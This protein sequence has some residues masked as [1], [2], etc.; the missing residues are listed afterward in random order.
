MRP[1]LDRRTLIPIALVALLAVARSASAW[2]DLGH[3]IIAVVAQANLTPHAAREVDRLLAQDRNG[4]R[5]RDGG[6]TADSFARQAAWADYYREAQRA[7][8]KP[9]EL[10]RSYSWHFVNIDV[11]GGS[12]D[13][14]CSDFPKLAPGVRASDGPDPDCIVNKI[15]QFAA[16]LAAPSTPDD[17]KLLALKFLLHLVGDVHQP[18]HVTDDMD[19]GGNGKLAMVSGGE[20]APLH[21]HWDTTFVERIGTA[22]GVRGIEPRTIARLLRKPDARE[23]A[24]WLGRVS[25]RDWAMDSYAVGR[26]AA[27]GRLP[28]PETIAGVPVYRLDDAYA[29]NATKVVAE[30]LNKAGH[31]LAALL[32]RGLGNRNPRLPL[33]HP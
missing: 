7:E 18:L 31:R 23:K 10:I 17:E 3:V 12:L 21:F 29:A 24:S 6:S 4:L 32:N 15:E 5:M 25:V 27:Y 30:Q 16:E 22:A 33:R 1:P 11:R 2:G 28:Q 9:R 26:T 14:A 19:R 20:P 13:A 8:G